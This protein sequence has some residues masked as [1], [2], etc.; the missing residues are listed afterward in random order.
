MVM[1]IKMSM[2]R[3]IESQ[4]NL[5]P[6]DTFRSWNMPTAVQTQFQGVTQSYNCPGVNMTPI[7]L[8]SASLSVFLLL[9]LLPSGFLTVFFVPFLFLTVFSVSVL[10]D[11]FSASACS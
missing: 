10:S 6:T 2:K 4:R 9:F 7:V 8:I 1:I 3:E 5:R 11:F